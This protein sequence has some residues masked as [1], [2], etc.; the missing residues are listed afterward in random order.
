MSHNINTDILLSIEY[1]KFLV[2]SGYSTDDVVNIV[3]KRK[4]GVVS[5]LFR[6]VLK[7]TELGRPMQDALHEQ[8]SALE[9]NI[10]GIFS[11]LTSSV[12]VD[13]LN[14][15]SEKIVQK[16]KSAVDEL[17][18][19]VEKNLGKIAFV[20]LLPFLYYFLVSLKDV[21]EAVNLQITVPPSVEMA[22]LG[23]VVVLLLILLFSMRYKE[24]A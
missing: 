22:A 8:E 16:R 2:N 12:P 18:E 6:N 23:L 4:L 5:D 3:S 20:L 19:K 9:G 24:N 10:K 11:A 13:Y 7:K 17:R 1:I 15:L 14:S 21:F